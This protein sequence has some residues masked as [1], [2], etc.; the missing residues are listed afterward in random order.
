[1]RQRN[2]LDGVDSG[3]KRPARWGDETNVRLLHRYLEKDVVPL[4]HQV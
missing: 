1:M 3:R 2:A 4:Q